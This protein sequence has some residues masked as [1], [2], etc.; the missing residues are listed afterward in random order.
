MHDEAPEEIH[1]EAA[2]PQRPATSPAMKTFLLRTSAS[3]NPT[4]PRRRISAINTIPRNDIRSAM[5]E[6]PRLPWW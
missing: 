5:I 6:G 2:R 4:P 3:L 1:A